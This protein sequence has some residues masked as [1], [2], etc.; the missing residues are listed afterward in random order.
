MRRR[1]W[2][3]VMR[4][5]H[6]INTDKLSTLEDNTHF[7]TKAQIKLGKEMARIMIKELGKHEK[8]I[9]A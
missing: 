1:G 3:P 5:C 8:K 2:L 6:I 4:M 9:R 7:D